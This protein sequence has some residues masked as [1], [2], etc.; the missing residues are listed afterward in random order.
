MNMNDL[1]CNC[2]LRKSRNIQTNSETGIE[3][4]KSVAVK[5]V[6]RE[7]LENSYTK[8]DIMDRLEEEFKYV[9]FPTKKTGDIISKDMAACLWRYI[10]EERA[11]GRT[12]KFVEPIKLN[13]F[14]TEITVRPDFI[15]CGANS[16]EVVKIRASKNYMTKTEEMEDKEL[17]ALLQYGKALIPVNTVGTVTAS[18]YFLRKKTDSVKDNIF[19]PGFFDDDSVKNGHTIISYADYIVDKTYN[20]EGEKNPLDYKFEKIY[21]DFFVGISEEDV[22]TEE[23]ERCDFKNICGYKNAPQYIVKEHKVKSISDL[24]LTSMQEKAISA[25][26]GLYR[27][28]AGAGAGKT[29]VVALRVVNLLLSGVKPKEICLLTFTN[30]GAS[31]MSERIQLYNADFGTGMDTSKI[32]S[33]TF[34]SFANMVIEKHWKDLGFTEKP[35]LIDDVERLSIIDDILGKTYIPGLD[36][37]NYDEDRVSLKGALAVTAKAFSI[38]KTYQLN[39]GDEDILQEKM[40]DISR[41]ISDPIA[42]T[43]LLEAYDDYDQILLNNNLIEYADQE[44]LMFKMLELDPYYFEK[45]GFKHIIVDEFQDSNEQQIR[46]I[47]EL[48][49]CPSYESLMVVGDDSQSIFSFRDT[50]PEYIVHF[51]ELMGE[52]GEDFFLLENHRSTPEIIDLANKI[53]ALNKEKVD[54]N[55]IATRDHGKKPVA[56]GYFSKED[57]L[58]EVSNKIKQKIIGEGAKAEDI[59]YIASDKFQLLEMGDIL[60]EKGI[61]WVMLNPE[62]VLEDAKVVATIALA[63]AIEN[64]DNTEAILT[65][66]NVLY[67]NKLLVKTDE[68]INTLIVGMQEQIKKFLMLTDRD[69][70]FGFFEMTDLLNDDE[71]ELFENFIEKLKHK[72]TFEQVAEYLRKF[73]RFGKNVT[74]KRTKD[75]PGVVLTT[76]HS[77]KGLEWPI[78]FAEITKFHKKIFG[79]N[80]A[81]GKTRDQAIEE[82]R[83]LLFVTITRARDELY[84][85]GQYK[86][87]GSKKDRVYNMFLKEVYDALDLAYDPIDPMEE[88]RERAAKERINARSRERRAKKKAELIGLANAKAV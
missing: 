17:Y 82:M 86:A 31:E 39:R 4:A 46:L 64:Y 7:A 34:N 38:I 44:I 83:R 71:D 65:Y 54:K 48:R 21:N 3:Y 1:K 52:D 60:T 67:S 23:C 2:S 24:S 36:Y 19:D 35:L 32:V 11:L 69:K 10:V 51:F 6:L 74:Y 5:K 70:Q 30:A 79:G 14:D 80:G 47:K 58:E 75:Y 87:F 63:K 12:I 50:T 53:N 49:S 41:F 20:P 61:P 59:A 81:S 13:I 68:E 42:Y 40:R 16:F 55:L 57:E 28:N 45:M 27:I 72:K 62:P 37:R 26:A 77:S 66:L 88:E 9:D 56:K 76:A 85:V 22:D 18:Y 84:V 73:E 78:V 8:K 25:K 15:V 33:C 29:L 43:Q